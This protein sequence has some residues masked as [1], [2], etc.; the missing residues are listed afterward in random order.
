MES[1]LEVAMEELKQK[2][3]IR[4]MQEQRNFY[5]FLHF[6]PLKVCVWPATGEEQSCK[7]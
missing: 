1:D 4:S 3:A 7:M 6:S 2:V 5:D